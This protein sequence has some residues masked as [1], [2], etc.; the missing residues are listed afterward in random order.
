[1]GMSTDESNTVNIVGLVFGLLSLVCSFLTLL[2]IYYTRKWNGYL[3][4]LTSMTFSQ[5]VY[6]VNYIMRPVPGVAA[7]YFVQ[8]CDLVGG[9]GVSF[10]TN[11][12]AFVI[13]YTV[14]FS[15]SINIFALYKYFSLFGYLLPISIGVLAVATPKVIVHTDDGLFGGCYYHRTAQG[16]FVYDFYYYGRLASVFITIFLC[17]LTFSKLRQMAITTGQTVSKDTGDSGNESR[18]ILRTVKKMNFYAVAQVICRSGAAWNEFYYGE[19]S[20]YES[21]MMAAICSPSSG[22]LNFF[23]FLVSLLGSSLP[24]SSFSSLFLVYATKCMEK[25]QIF[26]MLQDASTAAWFFCC[27]W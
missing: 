27:G 1:M 4:L 7:C 18:A 24:N 17:S 16:D 10:W 25:F 26:N 21:S 8:F 6:D 22:I 9:L 23:I 15:M 19:Y 3:L 5:I 14:V 20:T 13:T 12:L 2:L 11:I